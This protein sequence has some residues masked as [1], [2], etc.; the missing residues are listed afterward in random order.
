MAGKQMTGYFA[1]FEAQVPAG[2][3]GKTKILIEQLSSFTT[4][5]QMLYLL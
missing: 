3:A 4:I 2:P 1:S 5:L